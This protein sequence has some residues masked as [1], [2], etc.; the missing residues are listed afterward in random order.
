MDELS[1]RKCSSADNY[2][3]NDNSVSLRQDKDHYLYLLS[4]INEESSE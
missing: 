3:D 2:L 1:I 4:D